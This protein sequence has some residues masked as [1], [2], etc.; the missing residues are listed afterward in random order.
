MRVY[1]DTNVIY[2]YFKKRLQ[3]K[4]VN[5]VLI[6]FE[7]V[8]V[9]VYVSLFAIIEVVH[10]LKEDNVDRKKI[11]KLVSD[12]LREYRINIITKFTISWKTLLSTLSGVEWKDAVHLEIASQNDLTIITNDKKFF[13]NGRKLYSRIITLEWFLKHVRRNKA[14]GSARIRTGVTAS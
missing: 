6:F 8:K 1:L 2:G 12:F 11:S 7:D 9:D 14:D 4:P 5:T 10:R 3:E 13:K